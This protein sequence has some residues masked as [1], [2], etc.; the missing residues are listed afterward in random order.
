M[1]KN[2]KKKWQ[3]KK[4]KPIGMT[5]LEMPRDTIA[6]DEGEREKEIKI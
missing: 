5:S 6:R 4:S 1:K 2:G 3:E